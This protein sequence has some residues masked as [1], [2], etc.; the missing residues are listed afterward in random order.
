MI[1][2]CSAAPSFTTNQKKQDTLSA[3]ST[4]DKIHFIE[5]S[6]DQWKMVKVDIQ[7]PGLLFL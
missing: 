7:Y 6:S 4:L 1:E 3:R 5:L 2:R